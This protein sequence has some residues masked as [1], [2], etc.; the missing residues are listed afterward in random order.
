MSS[1]ATRQ[2]PPIPVAFCSDEGFIPQLAAALTSLFK[3]NWRNALEVHV[4][5]TGLTADKRALLEKLAATYGRELKLHALDASP[6]QDLAEYVQPRSTYYRLLLPGLLQEVSRLIYLD[7][8]LVVEIDLRELWEE[9]QGAHLVL[10]VAERDALQPGLQ[11]HVGTPGD[12]YINAGVLVM[13]LHA[14]RREQVSAQC[15][16]WLKENPTLAVMMDQD[17]I[18]RVCRGRKGYVPLKWNLNP[19]HGPARVTLPKF[20]ERIVHFAGPMKPWHAWYC[21]DLADIFYD[22]LRQSGTGLK[23]ERTGATKLGQHLSAANQCWERGD[24]LTAGR[25][26]MTIA[27]LMTQDKQDL[28]PIVR[29]CAA[30][31]NQAMSRGAFKEAGEHFRVLVAHWG[32]PVEHTDIY[33]IPLIR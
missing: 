2:M 10:G 15:L 5:T 27:H 9:A 7:C 23:V 31:G 16:Q 4:I 1:I 13:D 33:T 28:A 3:S 12:P 29:Y 17:A 20:P 6:L 14:W 21:Q 25:H 11:Q 22:Y 26:Y 8:D 32:L 19:V 30:L 18:N 24:H